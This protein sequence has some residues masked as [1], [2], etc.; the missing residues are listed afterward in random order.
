M[1]QHKWVSVL[2]PESQGQDL[3]LTVF[4]MLY[5]LDGRPYPQHRMVSTGPLALPDRGVPKTFTQTKQCTLTPKLTP[6]LTPN[7]LPYT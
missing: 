4:Y 7:P 3:A 1:G 2:L 5:S 6:N